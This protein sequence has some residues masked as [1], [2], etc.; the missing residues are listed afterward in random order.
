M[1]IDIDGLIERAKA[2]YA[3]GYDPRIGLTSEEKE[4]CLLASPSTILALCERLR[5]AEKTIQN[6]L[7]ELKAGDVQSAIDQLEAGNE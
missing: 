2:A 1:N 5:E 3:I 6:A 4:F 7:S